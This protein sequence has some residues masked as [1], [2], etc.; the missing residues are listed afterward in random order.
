M[1]LNFQVLKE[2]RGFIRVIQFVMSVF[3]FA[4]TSG[5]STSA[6][7]KVCDKAYLATFSFGYPFRMS[8]F[9]FNVPTICPSNMME[10]QTKSVVLPYN[11]ASNPEFFVATG[12]LSFLYCIGILGVYIFCNK[13]YTE[14]QTT[15]IVDLGLS[16]LLALFWFAGSS[17][18]AQGVR[19]VK[20]YTDPAVFMKL[21][22][23][24]GN[25]SNKCTSEST[26]N[27]ATLNVSL[28]LGFAN[29]LLWVAGCWFVF[30]ET[31]FHGQHPPPQGVAAP[32]Y[33]PVNSQYPPQSPPP[34]QSPTFGTQY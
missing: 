33:P 27:F 32:Q 25:A 20:Y 30:K 13:M 11:F 24:C 5:F 28:I 6:T 29:F 31:S 19:D 3:A 21:L 17:A 15:P 10:I 23:I 8:Y 7:F 22:E 12:V 1:D 14:N 9:P 2:P 18:W 34:V 26:G 4:T 16:C